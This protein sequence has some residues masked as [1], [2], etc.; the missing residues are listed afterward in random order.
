MCQETILLTSL[1]NDP[2]DPQILIAPRSRL[3]LYP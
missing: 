1:T 2:R 3:E